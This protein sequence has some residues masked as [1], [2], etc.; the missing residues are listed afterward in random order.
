[1]EEKRKKKRKKEKSIE[2][3]REL[4]KNTHEKKFMNTYI[5]ILF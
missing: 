5:K 3:K 1:M 4:K 2:D